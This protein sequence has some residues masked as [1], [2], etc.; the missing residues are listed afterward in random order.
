MSHS[1][2]LVPLTFSKLQLVENGSMMLLIGF[3]Q[4]T[5]GEGRDR[6]TNVLPS[7]HITVKQK[8]AG[9]KLK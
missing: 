5:S 1:R 3:E 4:Q 8:R 6:S 9:A 2:L 7:R